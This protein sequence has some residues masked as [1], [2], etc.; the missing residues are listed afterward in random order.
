MDLVA[1]C[2]KTQQE[3]DW[4]VNLAEFKRRLQIKPTEVDAQTATKLF[5]IFDAVIIILDIC[6]ELKQNT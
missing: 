5:A 2:T 3:G 6:F 4:F 1:E